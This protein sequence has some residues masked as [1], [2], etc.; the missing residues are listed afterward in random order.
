MKWETRIFWKRRQLNRRHVWMVPAD[1]GEA[2]RATS[3]AWSLP[4][5]LGT[6]ILD[7]GAFVVCAYGMRLEQ[8][9]IIS[10][11]GSLYGA[12]TVALAANCSARTDLALAMAGDRDNFCRHLSD[13]P[14]IRI[15]QNSPTR[16][17]EFTTPIASP[18][19][20]ATESRREGHAPR[21]EE[22]RENDADQSG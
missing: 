6:G 5:A 3:G 13:Q 15:L 17:K 2:K 8:V 22:R 11:L 18:K 1:G 9:A 20:S 4:L 7:T 10:V 21:T 19:G 14:L 16:M 12:V